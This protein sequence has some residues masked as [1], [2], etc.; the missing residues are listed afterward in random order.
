MPDKAADAVSDSVDYC[1]LLTTSAIDLIIA[2]IFFWTEFDI[3]FI[4]LILITSGLRIYLNFKRQILEND[5]QKTII[6]QNTDESSKALESL[7]NFET[8]KSFSMENYETGRYRKVVLE[9]GNTIYTYTT[10][11]TIF[12]LGF[13]IMV[14]ISYL[15][16]SL[17]VADRVKNG[18]MTPGTV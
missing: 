10:K 12:D 5:F 3:W 2:F 9:K 16:G 14:K 1:I 17:L 18:I 15:I 13:G 7:L 4:M 8:V 11:N 6:K